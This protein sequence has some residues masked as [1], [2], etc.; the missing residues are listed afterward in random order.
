[1]EE[2][3][4]KETVK[5]SKLKQI[6]QVTSGGFKLIY[7]FLECVITLAQLS[8]FLI[9]LLAIYV[10]LGIVASHFGHPMPGVLQIEQLLTNLFHKK[11]NG[12]NVK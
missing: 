2:Q 8:L 3:P 1:M 4:Q 6:R 7:R 10:V 9:V 12:G 5:T 11:S